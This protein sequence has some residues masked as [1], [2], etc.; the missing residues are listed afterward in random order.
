[1]AE[2]RLPWTFHR[3]VVTSPRRCADVAIAPSRGRRKPPLRPR[4]TVRDP[5]SGGPGAWAGS[6]P[7]TPP[8]PEP[9][10]AGLPFHRPGVTPCCCRFGGGG[11]LVKSVDEGGWNHHHHDPTGQA[12]SL[13]WPLQTPPDES[14]E[15]R[16]ALSFCRS[17]RA[18]ER[19]APFRL[20]HA[21]PATS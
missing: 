5:L 2:R 8:P 18:A 9:G 19:P 3:R 1:M 15:F 21:T 17:C 4:R 14:C 13:G 16:L 11:A 20:T 6:A 12:P 10:L 7:P